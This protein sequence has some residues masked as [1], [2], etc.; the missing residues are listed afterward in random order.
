MIGKCVMITFILVLTGAVGTKNYTFLSAISSIAGVDIA[1]IM[2]FTPGAAD[3][4]L[5]STLILRGVDGAFPSVPGLGFA[6]YL[7][8]VLYTSSNDSSRDSSSS[9]T[10]SSVSTVQS[11]DNMNDDSK[12]EL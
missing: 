9:S 6:I 4:F 12:I 7:G 10:D 8:F 5:H 1:A 3:A 11:T 2:T